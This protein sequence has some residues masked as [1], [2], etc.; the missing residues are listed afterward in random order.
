MFNHFLTRSIE[1]ANKVLPQKKSLQ[2]VLCGF[3]ILFSMFMLTGQT[4]L[5]GDCSQEGGNVQSGEPVLLFHNPD[6]N[7]ERDLYIGLAGADSPG[8]PTYYFA[9]T[10]SDAD[11]ATKHQL[12]L[13][14]GSAGDISD[15]SLVEIQILDQ[16]AWDP[17]DYDENLLG[18]FGDSKYLYYWTDYDE[19]THWIVERPPS[20]AESGPIQYGEDVLL[21][22]EH[23][24]EYLI[25][26]NP[27]EDP[28][29]LD[30]LTT[31]PSASSWKIY[32]YCSPSAKK[33]TKQSGYSRSKNLSKDLDQDEK[34]S[35]HV[36]VDITID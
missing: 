35:I 13:V 5:A 36:S 7:D 15:G 16:S 25:P 10:T 32:Q 12:N 20:S 1:R 34:T 18:G 19:K 3:F 8:L 27:V 9:K 11:L 21:L 30:F 4:A 2:G 17:D 24:L 23:Y 6:A 33:L 28:D 22:N 29:K 31:E 26:I 14:T